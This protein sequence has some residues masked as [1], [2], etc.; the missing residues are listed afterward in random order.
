MRKKLKDS[1]GLTMIE[2]LCATVILV[3]L[4]LMTGTGIQ[5]ALKNY[6]TLTAESETQLLLSSLTDALSDKLRYCVVYTD[7][8]TGAYKRCSIGEID[9]SSGKLIIKE[10]DA[11]GDPVEKPLL[12]EGAYG[13]LI[14]A[15]RKYKVTAE[16]GSF[17]PDITAKDPADPESPRTATFKIK[18]IVEETTGSISSKTPEEGLVIRCLNPVRKEEGTTP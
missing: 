5:M 18:L 1:G 3:L 17:T 16:A 15:E 7:K 2:M 10:T 14:G 11:T 12:P 9:A 13:E 4:C 8:T 6:H